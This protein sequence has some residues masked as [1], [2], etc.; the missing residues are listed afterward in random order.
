MADEE[1]HGWIP[2]F[3]FGVADRINCKMKEKAKRSRK[4]ESISQSINVSISDTHECAS[5]LGFSVVC[6]CF[7][8]SK[9]IFRNL[10]IFLKVL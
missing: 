8:V 3:D 4:R 5:A 7:Y 2:L 10:E 9:A 6:V 1:D